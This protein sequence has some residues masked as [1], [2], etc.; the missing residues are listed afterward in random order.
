MSKVM[1]IGIDGLD[2]AL[3]LKFR[4]ELPNFDKLIQESQFFK[5]E[6]VIP[7]DSFSAW[8]SIFTGLNPAEHGILYTP[9]V[10][11]KNKD[12]AKMN[13]DN[14]V[15]KGKTFW[16]IA[17]NAGK[18]VCILFPVFAYP[19]WKV[20]GIMV[21]RHPTNQGDVLAYP[22][23]LTEKY[24][25]SHL[26]GLTEPHPGASHLGKF[27]EHAK[28]VTLEEAKFGLEILR[29]K[30]DWD[31]FFIY[32]VALDEIKHFFWRYY[33][34]DDPTHPEDNPY[35]NVIKDFYKLLDSIVGDFINLV[36][37]ATTIVLS[38]HGH[39]MRPPKTVNINELLREK[40]YLKS[41]DGKLNPKSYLMER[42][43]TAALNFIHKHELD[44]WAVKLSRLAPKLS[45]EIY[46]SSSSI[47]WEETIAFLSQ[48]AGPKSYPHGGIEINTKNLKEWDYEKLRDALIE[49]IANLKRPDTGEAL[50][51]W[52]CR[53]ED[54][55]TGAHISKYPDIIFE[56]KEGYGVY[57]SIHTPLIG[58]AY[59]HNLAS[60][61]HKRDAVFLIS[62]CEKELT[63]AKTDM[64]LMD[65]APTVL[66][67][68]EVE[69]NSDL[70][71]GRSIFR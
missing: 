65:V 18:E 38:D 39:G 5:S 49:V 55:Y 33:D 66:D 29:S 48:F 6:S 12:R 42:I 47:D 44:Y 59:E 27:F 21:S 34:E 14:R 7:V 17:G 58:T 41:R 71:D 9:D 32:L 11:E 51:N 46:T 56:L 63:I 69:Q 23:T 57:W 36:P 64:T 8:V 28:E 35:K 67:I 70:N 40:G 22:S 62:N 16:D 10:F 54:L 13:I 25:I 60:G 2:P 31:L 20:N 61:G 43:K 53:R 19:P 52:V 45:K 37:D 1:M 15:L 30:S 3:L 26:R 24:E 68:L 50:V 4:D